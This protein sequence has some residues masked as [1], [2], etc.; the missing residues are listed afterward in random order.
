MQSQLYSYIADD[1]RDVLRD[2]G[3]L[4]AF[5]SDNPLVNDYYDFPIGS[6]ME[7]SGHF[8]KVPKDIA[9]GRN[10][11]GTDLMAADKGFP[12]PPNDGTWQRGPDGVTGLDGPQWVLEHWGDIQPAPVFQFVRLEDIAYDRKRSNVV[13]IADTGRGA[14]SAGGNAF[15][16]TNGRIWKLVLDRKNPKKAKLSILVEGDDNPVKTLNEIHQPDNLESTKDGLFVTEDPGSSQQFPVGST[17]PNTTTARL[18]HVELRTGA[19]SVI[20]KVNQS[21]DEGPD[22]PRRGDNAGEPRRLGDERHRGRIQVLRQGCVPHRHPSRH[23]GRGGGGTRHADLP[24]RRRSA[25]AASRSGLRRA[26][27]R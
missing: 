23:A 15:T 2:R 6:T 9:T 11:D 1:R 17:D 21:A 25:P 20:A 4:W 3:D 10:P 16:S 22:R 13:Y 26:R 18:W 8:V 5:V 24:A 7:V 14:T 27:R 19:T 12:A